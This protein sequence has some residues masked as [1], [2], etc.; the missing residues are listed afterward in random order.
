MRVVNTSRWGF[1]LSCSFY[2]FFLDFQKVQVPQ[3]Y[4]PSFISSDSYT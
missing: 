2:I 3:I 1:L 4:T